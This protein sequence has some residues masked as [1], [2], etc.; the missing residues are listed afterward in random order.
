MT[1]VVY[2]ILNVFSEVTK[3]FLYSIIAYS[4]IIY[5]LIMNNIIIEYYDY[6]Y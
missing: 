6:Y 1:L 3:K 2:I 5:K 4:S